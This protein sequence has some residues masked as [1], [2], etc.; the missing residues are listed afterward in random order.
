[1]KSLLL[2]FTVLFSSYSMDSFN[3]LKSHKLICSAQAR[4]NA[5]GTNPN[6]CLSLIKYFPWLG[7]VLSLFNVVP[8]ALFFSCSW[9]YPS[10][11][12]LPTQ[13]DLL[14]RIIKVGE[15]QPLGESYFLLL[16]LMYVCHRNSLQNCA[17][18]LQDP[19]Q[20]ES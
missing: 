20:S 17:Q 8:F 12:D 19:S 10:N 14:C 5:E 2:H 16:S 9:Q 4:V 7:C 15:Y 18:G 3:N 6:F 13:P 11:N 1:M